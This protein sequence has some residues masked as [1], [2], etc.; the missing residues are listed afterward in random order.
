VALEVPHVYDYTKKLYRTHAEVIPNHANP[1]G[2]DIGQG[3]ARHRKYKRLKFGGSQAY[4]R[5]AD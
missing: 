2:R 3:E 4:D 5:S 1:N